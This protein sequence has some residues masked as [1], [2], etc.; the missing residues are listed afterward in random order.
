MDLILLLHDLILNHGIT[1]AGEN[2]SQTSS[3]QNIYY[4][5]TF[6][7]QSHSTRIRN[8]RIQ[9]KWLPFC[10]TTSITKSSSCDDNLKTNYRPQYHDL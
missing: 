5:V 3:I 4:L 7:H 6:I 2:K 10:E 9:H 8:D 1:A